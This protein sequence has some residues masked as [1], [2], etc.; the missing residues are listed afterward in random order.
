[1]QNGPIIFYSDNKRCKRS[2]REIINGMKNS[3]GVLYY[4]YGKILHGKRENYKF[5]DN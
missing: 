1:M 2:D 3:F 4:K 5:L